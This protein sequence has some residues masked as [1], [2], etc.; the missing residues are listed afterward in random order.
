A[1]SAACNPWRTSHEQYSK[2]ACARPASPA[3]PDRGACRRAVLPGRH[4]RHHGLDPVFDRRQFRPPVER[5]R[6]RRPGRQ[7]AAAGR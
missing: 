1:V 4:R 2:S 5:G 3:T 6:P 7:P